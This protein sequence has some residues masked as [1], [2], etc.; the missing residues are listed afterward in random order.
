[1]VRRLSL[2]SMASPSPVRSSMHVHYLQEEAARVVSGRMGYQGSGRLRSSR[3]GE[4]VARPAGYG[5]QMVECRTTEPDDRRVNR[6]ATLS[7]SGRCCS[8]RRT[9]AAVPTCSTRLPTC[10]RSDTTC[11]SFRFAASSR[12]TWLVALGSIRAR[13]RPGTSLTRLYSRRWLRVSSNCSASQE[14]SVI[15]HIASSCSVIPIANETQL[16]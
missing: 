9:A 7:S 2:T 8:G 14:F 10:Y 15:G 12:L 5:A 1:M 13:R 3:V 4:L 11:W 6:P 16:M